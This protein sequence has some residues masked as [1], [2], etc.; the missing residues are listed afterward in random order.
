[1]ATASLLGWFAR[2]RIGRAMGRSRR[3]DGGGRRPRS[4]MAASLERRGLA[5]HLHPKFYHPGRHHCRVELRELPPRLPAVGYARVSSEPVTAP[6]ACQPTLGCQ[7]S[8]TTP[9]PLHPE[10]H[11]TRRKRTHSKSS[12][13]C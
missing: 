9:L 13:F 6:Q 2:A 10:S 3:R 4:D 7:L 11:H 1:R 8:G 12:L 5:S